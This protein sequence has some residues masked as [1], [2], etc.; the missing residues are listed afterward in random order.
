MSL[1]L[2]VVTWQHLNNTSGYEI[3]S[4]GGVKMSRVQQFNNLRRKFLNY[5]L[6]HRFS[7]VSIHLTLNIKLHFPRT[8]TVNINNTNDVYI[9]A[10]QTNLYWVKKKEKWYFIEVCH[11][12]L[13]G[14]LLLLQ[15]VIFKA[16]GVWIYCMCCIHN[17]VSY[18]MTV[19]RGSTLQTQLQNCFIKRRQ[20]VIIWLSALTLL[21]SV[22]YTLSVTD[23]FLFVFSFSWTT[24]LP[25]TGTA[26][27]N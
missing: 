25:S 23:F 18:K 17:F 7:N 8:S 13:Y 16:V 10:S 26:A 19:K 22:F 15:T 11:S 27:G 3:V 2:N 4:V 5:Y 24:F 14:D 20:N 21:L 9:N 1:T 12:D 6:K